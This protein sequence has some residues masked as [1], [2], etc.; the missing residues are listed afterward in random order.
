M[1]IEFCCPACCTTL[2]VKDDVAGG[3][4]NCPNCQKLIL[5]P[6]S[7]PFGRVEGGGA[8]DAGR[9]HE[10][11]AVKRA[12]SISV[13]P[14]RR[15]LES[16]GNLLNEAVEMVKT[17]NRR[18][19]EIE[20]LI[21]KV[22]KDLWA[23][24][25]EHEDTAART[26]AAEEAPSENVLE[27][28]E[29]HCRELSERATKLQTRNQVLHERLDRA[30]QSLAET[31]AYVK[32]E[33]GLAAEMSRQ[34]E[35]LR[36]EVPGMLEQIRQIESDAVPGP[37]FLEGL[38]RAGLTLQRCGEEIRRLRERLEKAELELGDKN[39]SVSELQGALEKNLARKEAEWQREKKADESRRARLQEDLA[40]QEEQLQ[41]ALK[42]Q[43]TLAEQCLKMENERKDLKR[44]LSDALEK[45]VVL[46][47][48]G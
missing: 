42:T 7:S 22:Q 13:E 23:L 45:I 14:Y 41:S 9:Q 36:G 5:I 21:L 19:R 40:E 33:N 10:V 46:E 8:F 31:H 3:Q 17:R 38:R 47:S 48:R 26:E 4:V 6:V 30:L 1:L 29:T 44:R 39:Q 16:K 11:E 24:E 28:L 12:I 15:E 18:I 20:S 2:A 43:Q 37:V 27:E 35:A 25:V 34:I 32:E